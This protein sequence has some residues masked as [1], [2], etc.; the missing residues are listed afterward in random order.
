MKMVTKR[1][2]L[3]YAMDK[4]IFTIA[5]IAN[6][7]GITEKDKQTLR[8]SLIHLSKANKLY[9]YQRGVYGYMY[10][11][12]VSKTLI[13]CPKEEAFAQL[14]T[15]NDEGYISGEYFLYMLGLSSS[16]PMRITIVT[17]KVRKEKIGKSA[18]F[19]P[20]KV[21]ITSNNKAYLQLLDCIENF[22]NFEIDVNDPYAIIRQYIMDSR[23]DIVML[24]ALIK[25][26]YSKSTLNEL[27]R[28]LGTS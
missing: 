6:E 1:E 18:V 25:R 4:Q 26:C 27:N 17:N 28:C 23:L 19:L 20:A 11:D 12:E 5:E 15:R 16:I 24:T 8:Q 2:I 3:K 10:W 13:Y 14:Y 7:F 21:T 9:H 22:R